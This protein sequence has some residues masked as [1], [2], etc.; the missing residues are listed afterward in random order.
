MVFVGEF[1]PHP[2]LRGH[3]PLLPLRGISPRIGGVYPLW[4]RLGTYRSRANFLAWLT[5]SRAA[6]E[7]AVRD[8]H[9]SPM[10]RLAAGSSCST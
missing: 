6:G 8:R 3:R 2:A 7:S 10:L 1:D 9:A 4:G 5:N